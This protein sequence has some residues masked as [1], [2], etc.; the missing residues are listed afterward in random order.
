MKKKICIIVDDKSNPRSILVRKSCKKVSL[1]FVGELSGVEIS[2]KYIYGDIPIESGHDILIGELTGL[3]PNNELYMISFES[4]D[5]L[6]ADHGAYLC[7]SLA[8][9]CK[10]IA[11]LSDNDFNAPEFIKKNKNSSSITFYGGSFNPWHEGHRICV[12]QC[13]QDNIVIVPDFNPWKSIDQSGVSNQCRWRSFKNI[14][15]SVGDTPHSV[16]PGFW[17]INKPNPTSSWMT[18]VDSKSVNMIIGDDTF[19]NIDKWYEVEKLFNKLK[20]IYVI[21]RSQDRAQLLMSKILL[22]NKFDIEFIIMHEHSFQALSSTSI[23]QA[24]TS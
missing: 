7:Q 9:M 20:K 3:V 17:G 10:G 14:V 6:E 19:M 13:Q 11:P 15:L 8:L 1:P 21:P 23:R 4:L 5:E 22:E 2:S 16:Y 12:D 18:L 24:I